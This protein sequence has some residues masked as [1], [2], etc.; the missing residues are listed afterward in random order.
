MAMQVFKHIQGLQEWLAEMRRQ[1]QR[2]GL[3]PTM[4]NLHDGHM[5]LI[6]I[7]QTHCDQV[8]VSIF[9]NPLQFGLNEDWDKYPRTYEADLI[10][11]R[12][13]GCDCLFCP[14][15]NDI[16]PNGMSEQTKVTVPVMPDILCGKSRP[17]H[18]DGVTTIVAKLFHIIQPDKA[19]FGLKDF[20]QLTIIRRMVEDLCF[21]VRI[22]AGDIVREADGLA[23][24]SRNRFITDTERP[25]AKQLYQTLCWIKAQIEEGHKDYLTLESKAREQIIDAGFRPDYIQVCNS[26]TLQ[27]AAGDNIE[28]AVLGAMYTESARL[29]DNVS[30]AKKNGEHSS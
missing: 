27:P 5:A 10:K 9:V 24:S 13:V 28:L 18:F 6:K 14:N 30:I 19:V 20:Q 11:L 23:M 4:G 7:A 3:V 22:V 29:I 2:I 25:A 8:V 17:G 26:T 21:P 12:S 16:Y 15:E 1:Y